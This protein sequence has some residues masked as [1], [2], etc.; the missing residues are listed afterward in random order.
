VTRNIPA[1][2]GIAVLFAAA[3]CAQ[4]VQVE[5]TGKVG[6]RVENKFYVAD[7]SPS[8]SNGHD[9]D[10]GTLRALTFKEFNVTFFRNAAN[11]RMHKGPSIQR[12]GAT[13]YK[14]QGSW[15]PVQ[16]FREERKGS[17]YIHH[18][19][20]YFPTYPEVR[21]ISEYRFP[22]DAP[23]FVVSTILAVEK[24]IPVVMVRNN[25]MTM[26][27]FFT[28]L[29]WPGKDGTRHMVEFDKR[30]PL[31]EQ[32]P[33][34]ADVPWL[35]FVNPEKGYGYG[36]VMLASKATKTANAD[37]TI[38]DG[39]LGTAERAEAE[40][41]AKAEGKTLGRVINARYFSRHLISGAEVNLAP[42]DRFEELTAYVLFH[43]SP[44]EPMGNFFDW[45]K[46]IRSTTPASR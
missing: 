3:A 21:V 33:I 4:T 27:L 44:K 1:K 13:S 39:T 10:S 9:E 37:I 45:E 41:K 30:A 19:E 40:A 17:L 28:H 7:L 36:F 32:H 38:A 11:G 23:Y 26:N 18:R 35:A 46:R 16:E 15:D 29:V 14:D 22:A 25:E 5:N 31:I 42:G 43:S 6:R 12:A 20:G 8:T 2:L 34:P 24:P